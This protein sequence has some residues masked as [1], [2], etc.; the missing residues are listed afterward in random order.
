MPSDKYLSQLDAMVARS[1][2]IR[3][4][5]EQLAGFLETFNKLKA[6]THF[7][8]TVDT[9]ENHLVLVELANVLEGKLFNE[10]QRNIA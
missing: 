5:P 10:G 7:G 3:F 9:R 4:T 2:A 6:I 1:E 8:A